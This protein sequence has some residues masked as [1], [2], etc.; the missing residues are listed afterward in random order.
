MQLNRG[1]FLENG[2]S[3]YVL[4]PPRL[5]GITAT[6]E[7]HSLDVVVTVLSCS[8]LPAVSSSDVFDPQVQLQLCGR[9]E[10]NDENIR[11]TQ[12]LQDNGFN[13][14]FL[15]AEG[16]KHVAPTFTFHVVDADTALL[17]LCIYETNKVESK[18][19]V[20]HAAIP[21]NCLRAGYRS[22]HL[23]NKHNNPI[24]FAT[25]LCRFEATKPEDS[26]IS[27]VGSRRYH[28]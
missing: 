5:R 28:V 1:R 23:F 13:P 18:E 21:I 16:D 10:D 22:V 9:G 26:P 19:L 25:I 15:K 24:P 14:C 12:K 8:R 17:R 4:K 3:G 27:R 6:E 7:W 20:G 11:K 2:G